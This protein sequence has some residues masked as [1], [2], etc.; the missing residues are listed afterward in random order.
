MLCLRA[1]SDFDR[2]QYVDS[3]RID[4]GDHGHQRLGQDHL[5]TA[6]RRGDEGE[7]GRGVGGRRAGE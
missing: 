6:H 5:A 3:T 1:A 2:H 4:G 7:A